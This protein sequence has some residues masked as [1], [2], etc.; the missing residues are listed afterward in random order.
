MVPL[1]LFLN[2]VLEKEA[3]GG[4][5]IRPRATPSFRHLSYWVIVLRCTVPSLRLRGRD[6]TPRD[7]RSLF[8]GF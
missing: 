3:V 1:Y 7:L 6:E 8:F 5:P 2:S 4:L